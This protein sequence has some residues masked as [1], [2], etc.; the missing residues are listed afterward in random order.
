MLTLRLPGRPKNKLFS[1][2]VRPCFIQF[3]RCSFGWTATDKREESPTILILLRPIDRSPPS[4]APSGLRRA[5]V[6]QATK[7]TAG[8]NP[9]L[10]ASQSAR[11]GSC[12]VC[13]EKGPAMGPFFRRTT[14]GERVG[15]SWAR[16]F[17]PFSLGHDG[18]VVVCDARRS[19]VEGCPRE[20]TFRRNP[21]SHFGFKVRL[22]YTIGL[23]P[24]GPMPHEA[25]SKCGE[26]SR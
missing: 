7:A 10:S 14:T 1:R 8:S 13:S 12:R 3:T 23:N 11:V 15:H 5:T 6:L 24:D 19:G 26:L 20:T 4:G 17:A 9:M 21:N 2:W 25:F 16:Q 22:V 18:R